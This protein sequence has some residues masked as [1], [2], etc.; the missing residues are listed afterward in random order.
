MCSSDLS[1][2][3]ERASTLRIEDVFE[4]DECKMWL[5]LCVLVQFLS[6]SPLLPI[7]LKAT[8]NMNYLKELLRI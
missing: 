6:V 1:T 8:L 7:V 3:E 4:P 5:N 2:V